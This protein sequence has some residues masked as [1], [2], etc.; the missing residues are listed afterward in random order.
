MRLLLYTVAFMAATSALGNAFSGT[1]TKDAAK[2]LDGTWQCIGLAGFAGPSPA[3]T[4]KKI[5]IKIAGTKMT[6]SKGDKTFTAKIKTDFT[7][8]P[9]EIDMVLEDGPDKGQIQLGLFVLKN[10]ELII[11]FAYPGQKRSEDVTYGMSSTELLKYGQSS[12]LM[13]FK[14]IK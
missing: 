2:S 1:Q 13:I 11:R 9:A 12:S 4:V 10:D 7:K 5:R 6:I 8:K 14:R 3:E